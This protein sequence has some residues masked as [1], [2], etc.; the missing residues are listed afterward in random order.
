MRTVDFVRATGFSADRDHLT[1]VRDGLEGPS[2]SFRF[3]LAT[4]ST[5]RMIVGVEMIAT[6]E[7]II[8]GR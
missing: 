6:V 5:I 1:M 4:E 2:Y 7:M 3:H 8:G